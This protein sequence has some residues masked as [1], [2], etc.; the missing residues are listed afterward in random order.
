M[1]QLSEPAADAALTGMSGV[2]LPPSAGY[3][4]LSGAHDEMLQG[5]G[6][7][8]RH[9]RELIEGF[10]T[11]GHAGL[12]RRWQAAQRMIQDNGVTYNVY[13]DPRGVDRTWN[14]DPVPFTLDPAEWATVEAGLAQRSEVLNLVL[15]DLYGPQR[16]LKDKLLPSDLVFANPNFLRPCHGIRPAPGSTAAGGRGDAGRHLVLHGVD[17]ARNPRGQWWVIADRTQAPS[18]AG[19]ALENRLV[20]SRTFPALFRD[21]GVRRL[22]LFFGELRNTLAKMV[23]EGRENPRIVLL[24][25]GPYNETYFEHA[26]LSRYL[27]FTLVE[28]SDLTVR[29]HRVYLKTLGGLQR[30]DVILRRLDDSYCDPLELRGDSALGV[31]GLVQAAAAG[32]VAIANALGSGLIETPALM[33]FFP[34]LC[35]T[36][37]GE[38]PKLPAVATW[39]CGQPKERAYVLE[40]LA[41][42]VVKPAFPGDAIEP[43]FGAKLSAAERG[44]LKDRI[45]A[46]PHRYVAQESV[47]LSTAPVWEGA[48]PGGGASGG[49]YTPRHIM[50]R[51]FSA[52]KAEGGY[53]VMPGGLVRVSAAA[54]SMIVSMQRGGGSKDAWVLADGPVSRFSLLQNE[55]KVVAVSRTAADLPSRVA[56]GMYWLGRYVERAEGLTRLMRAVVKRFTEETSPD[57][58]PELPRLFRTLYRVTHNVPGATEGGEFA[59]PLGDYD[60]AAR[61]VRAALFDAEQG[62]SLR[63]TIDHARRVGSVVRDRISVDT[64]RILRQI[65]R[66]FRDDEAEPGDLT[67][68]LTVLDR[69]MIPLYA[70]SGLSHESMTHTQGWR[71]LDMGRRVERAAATLALL[72][73]LLGRSRGDELPTLDATL[74]VANSSMTYRSRYRTSLSAMPVVDLLLLDESNPRSVGFQLAELM[75]HVDAL[76]RDEAEGQRSPEQRLMLGMLSGVQLADVAELTRVEERTGRRPELV[77]LLERLSGGLPEFSDALTQRY[78][79]HAQASVALV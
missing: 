48:T 71:F 38:E 16:L 76:P 40:H 5:A 13:G 30:V 75:R 23:P 42:L 46:R 50:M 69:L 31:T 61:Y 10:N 52:A 11:I 28:G 21:I 67:A 27:G 63:A 12:A 7:V 65:D 19:Y 18:G 47:A 33:P 39:W 66:D 9:W 60:R 54:E 58:C 6:T 2:D 4:G 59:D 77:G 3:A 51:A 22:A 62:F 41:E 26:Y 55:A 72:Q 45:E 43:V 34:S 20:I 70:F 56:D 17:L 49:G 8:R 78:L 79:T 29:D 44:A 37:L 14:L 57:G 68:A 25:P 15:A 64:W 36:L 24:T 1:S 53:A 32:Q 73:E 35:R 74:E